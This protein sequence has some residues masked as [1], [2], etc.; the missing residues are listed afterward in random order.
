M[1]DSEV[2]EDTHMLTQDEGSSMLTEVLMEEWSSLED[3]ESFSVEFIQSPC[4]SPSITT[5]VQVL[6]QTSVPSKAMSESEVNAQ[7][8]VAAKS[9]V[10]LSGLILLAAAGFSFFGYVMMKETEVVRKRDLAQNN[11]R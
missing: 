8:H 1:R 3:L 10:Y 5:W 7:E 4:F 11:G 9:Y 2:F 6:G